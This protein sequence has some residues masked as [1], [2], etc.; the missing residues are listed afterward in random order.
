MTNKQKILN[1]MIPGF[2]YF[3]WQLVKIHYDAPRYLRKLREGGRVESAQSGKYTKFRVR[4]TKY[5]ESK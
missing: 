1:A 3:S 5:I 4:P 2:W